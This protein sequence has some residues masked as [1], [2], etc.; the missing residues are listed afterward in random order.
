M[1]FNCG[2]NCVEFLKFGTCKVWQLTD[3]PLRKQKF[4]HY[5]ASN[6]LNF[7]NLEKHKHK[8]NDVNADYLAFLRRYVKYLQQKISVYKFINMESSWL[9]KLTQKSRLPPA[10][11]PVKS[12]E[13]VL[14]HD[15]IGEQLMRKIGYIES[16]ID[17]LIGEF[18]AD[19]LRLL[20]DDAVLESS[21]AKTKCKLIELVFSLLL[22]DVIN[23]ANFYQDIMSELIEQFEL[24]N[25][26]HCK[27]AIEVYRK[28]PDKVEMLRNF[29]LDCNRC[30]L[31]ANGFQ[32]IDLSELIEPSVELQEKM[33]NHW[34]LLE[35]KP[36]RK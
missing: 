3:R 28:L 22:S 33:E 5:L 23:Y 32:A 26:K 25:R 15:I 34:N 18:N 36:K 6:N 12:D 30:L 11:V 24:M 27:D 9:I 21:D 10:A 29:L 8:F 20:F 4:L 7:V 14:Q 2:L 1:Q 17:Y 19:N 13:S 31:Q 16:Q 35:S